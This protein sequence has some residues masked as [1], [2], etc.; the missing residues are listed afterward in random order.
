[1]R[2]LFFSK[3]FTTIIVVLLALCALSSESRAYQKFMVPLF[4][5][6]A[7]SDAPALEKMQMCME[8]VRK[9]EIEAKRKAGE[10]VHFGSIEV[11]S[12]PEGAGVLVSSYVPLGKTPFRKN[13]ILT[14]LQRVTMR[15]EG[16]YEQVRMVEITDGDLAKER[17]KLEPIPYAR[18]TLEMTPGDI[19]ARIIGVA[20]DYTPGMKLEPGD[21]LVEIK[22]PDYG[23]H[24]LYVVAQPDQN[25][26]LRADLEAERGGIEIEPVQDG[27]TVYLD[28]Q[29]VFKNKLS[30]KG[31]I[32]GPHK[33]QVWKS[34]YKPATKSVVVQPGKVQTAAIDLEQ[35]EHFSNEFGM[36]FVKIPAGKFMMGYRDSPE[37]EMVKRK[38]DNKQQAYAFFPENYP[39]HLVEI[40]K[41]FFMQTAEVSKDQLLQ[42]IGNPMHFDLKSLSD[43]AADFGIDPTIQKFLEQL[44]A[45]SKGKIRYRLPTEAEWEYACR[46]GTTSPFYT[47]ETIGPDQAYYD[48]RNKPYGDGKNKKT[49]LWHRESIKHFSPN[50]WGLYDMHGS[51]AEP[52]SD[53]IDYFFYTF[54]PVK[55]P[56]NRSSKPGLYALRGGKTRWPA[57]ETACGNRLT[58]H[59]GDGEISI[60]G[61]RLVAE[62]LAPPR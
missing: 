23:T 24:R 30:L 59:K 9:K 35:A 15:K 46:A 10:P 60:T 53:W 29:E 22:H 38:L 49:K 17:F 31:L 6:G 20:Q 48:W 39:R 50:P 58:R 13:Q 3:T 61:L 12:Q 5:P 62:R 21:Y 42:I 4:F 25:I 57:G 41:P 11:T 44:N 47:G 27:V 7:S 55:D 43:Q 28:G 33:L 51:N 8:Y 18:L 36:T 19:K 34:L 32:P 1:M 16:Y 54:S 52:C 56:E 26:E 40:T 2:K 14:G 45:S 37:E